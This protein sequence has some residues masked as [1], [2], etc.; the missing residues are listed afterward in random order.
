M[1]R[2]AGVRPFANGIGEILTDIRMA[3]KTDTSRWWL[4]GNGENWWN[5][6]DCYD[7]DLLYYVEQGRFQL[8]VDDVPYIISPGQLVYI[9]GG[10][11]LEYTILE[12]APLVKYYIHFYALIGKCRPI[13]GFGPENFLTVTDDRL[14]QDLETLC[15]SDPSGETSLFRLHGALM[16][17]LQAFFD[18]NSRRVVAEESD[19]I[20]ASLAYI[21]GHYREK[22]S[23]EFLANHTGFSRDYYSK[24]FTAR[25]GCSPATYITNLRIRQARYLLTETQ[26]PVAQIAD[27]VGISDS[28]YFS[29]LF[30]RSVG[31]YPRKYRFMYQIGRPDGSK[32]PAE[33]SPSTSLF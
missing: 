14:L 19:P 2:K 10:K 7:C 24:K 21:N 4:D 23:V 17:I 26:M 11:A 13:T 5:R 28:N 32:E 31:L 33:D 3:S 22:L 15:C 1:K 25:Y 18:G 16:N 6:K 27:A 8:K 30:N 29:R 12:D 20:A 9:P